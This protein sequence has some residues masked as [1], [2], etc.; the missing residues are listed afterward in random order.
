MEVLKTCESLNHPSH[1]DNVKKRDLA[2]TK[3]KKMIFWHL[4]DEES[5]CPTWWFDQRAAHRRKCTVPI[6]DFGEFQDDLSFHTGSSNANRI[7]TWI[8]PCNRQD[9]SRI[10]MSYQSPINDKSLSKNTSL[11]FF[12]GLS[13]PSLSGKIDQTFGSLDHWKRWL[14]IFQNRKRFNFH[15]QTASGCLWRIRL[16]IPFVW[17]SAEMHAPSSPSYKLP[18]KQVKNRRQWI[19]QN[20]EYEREYV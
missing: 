14:S 10:S 5:C 3:W 20:Q 6:S 11:R 13:C 16:Q 9:G 17:L 18:T 2:G 7:I 15:F 1:A 8:P 12:K 4:K 19:M